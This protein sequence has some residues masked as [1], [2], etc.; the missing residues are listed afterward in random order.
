MIADVQAT[1]ESVAPL[2]LGEVWTVQAVPSHPSASATSAPALV[3]AEPTATHDDV[4]T[5]LTLDNTL[6]YWYPGL[7]VGSTVHALPFQLSASVCCA[8]DESWYEPTAT[9][10][11]DD[12]HE[13]PAN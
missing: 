6:T 1:P 10:A 12:V 11:V 9:H 7:V 8:F 5:Q 13:T 3:S 4:D 2:R